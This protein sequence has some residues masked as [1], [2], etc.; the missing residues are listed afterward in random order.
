MALKTG[1]VTIGC[2]PPRALAAF[3]AVEVERLAGSGATVLD[4]RAVSGLRWTVFGNEFWVA[5]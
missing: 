5:G 4:E 3:C 2:V 1:M